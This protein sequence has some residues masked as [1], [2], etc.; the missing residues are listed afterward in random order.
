MAD[1]IL[2]FNGKAEEKIHLLDKVQVKEILHETSWDTLTH[3]TLV[4]NDYNSLSFI[5]QNDEGM[6][7]LILNSKVYEDATIYKNKSSIID[8]FQMFLL[9]KNRFKLSRPFTQIEK[10]KP[11]KFKEKSDH[12]EYGNQEYDRSPSTTYSPTPQRSARPPARTL[13]QRTA[14]RRNSKKTSEES[15]F[16]LRGIFWII[17]L[18]YVFFRACAS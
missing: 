2:K 4:H 3:I 7:G 14:Q 9:E 12:Y 15:G 17:G 5:K 8:S 13:N 18:V 16:S 6:F 11:H 1:L 10:K